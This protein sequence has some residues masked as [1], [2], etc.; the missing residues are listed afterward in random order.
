MKQDEPFNPNEI[1]KAY[2][3]NLQ[4]RLAD[5]SDIE[6]IF[7]LMSLRNP[8]SDKNELLKKTKREVE[9]WS[10][11]KQYGL[12]VSVLNDEVIGFCRYYHS[13]GIPEERRRYPA[14]AGFYAMGTMVD[15]HWRRHSIAR[16]LSMKRMEWL[17]GLGAENI[18]SI[19]SVE[20]LSSIKMHL[21]FG[22]E[23]IARAPGFLNICFENAEGIL[24]RL[25]L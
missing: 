4:F 15:P 19:V 3:E 7:H 24:F 2:P 13:D 17:K 12:F 8:N 10:D 14:P 1:S 23:E 16:F 9:E 11:G 25:N 20:N 22:Y 6:K 5:H 18:F 21:S